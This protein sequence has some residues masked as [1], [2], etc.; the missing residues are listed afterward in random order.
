MQRAVLFLA[1][2]ALASLGLATPVFAATPSNDL[3]VGRTVIPATPSTD[4]V[5]TTEATTDADDAELVAQCEAPAADASVWYEYTAV[6]DAGLAITTFDSDYPVGVIVATGAPGGFSVVT[7]GPGSVAFSSAP[8]ETYAILLFD[9]Q[10]DGGGNGGSLSMQL[11]ELPPPPEL[12][13]TVS[14]SG[15]FDP[16][17]GS[18]TIRG[19]VTCTGGD[20]YSKTSIDVQV[21]QTVGRLRFNGQGFTTF[22]CDGGSHPWEAEA[23]SDD[24]K[25]AGGKASVHVFGFVCTETGCDEAE[26]TANVILRR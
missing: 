4:S 3:S 14:P 18:A 1:T 19:T 15:S 10:G 25:F 13:V 24:G 7:C 2:M 21:S 20:A 5:D 9:F 26:L 16:V 12:D 6:S 17:T 22:A 23:F 11:A 8:G